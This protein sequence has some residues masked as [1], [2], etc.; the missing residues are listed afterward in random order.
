MVGPFGD[1]CACDHLP[2]LYHR[3]LFFFGLELNSLSSRTEWG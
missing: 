1:K 3:A 2:V